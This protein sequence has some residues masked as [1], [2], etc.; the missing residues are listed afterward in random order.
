MHLFPVVGEKNSKKA[1]EPTDGSFT[2]AAQIQNKEE[3]PVC[4]G[5]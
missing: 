1:E 3:L 2:K 4:D 5:Y